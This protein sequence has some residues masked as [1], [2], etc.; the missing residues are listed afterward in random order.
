MPD[1][2]VG[3]EIAKPTKPPG[4]PVLEHAR[5]MTAVM[6]LVWEN[7]ESFVSPFGDV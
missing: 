1:F 5:R 6:A 3:N 2:S 7:A 4:S